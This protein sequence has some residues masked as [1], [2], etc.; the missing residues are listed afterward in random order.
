MNA[1]CLLIVFAK[2]PVPGQAKTRLAPA[3]G[4]EGAAGL[5]S[6][7]LAHTLRSAVDSGI[8]P[9]ELCCAPDTGHAQF[10]QAAG[11][12]VSLT[13]QGGG[14]LGERMERAL[15]R[16]LQHH[17]RVVLIGTDAPLLD[18]AVLRDAATALLT[19]DVVIAPAADG[20][21]VLVGLARRAPELFASVAWSTPLVMAQTRAR[22]AALGLS[23]HELPTLHDIDEPR[24]LVHVPAEWQA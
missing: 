21:Y 4:F 7:M 23:L 19:H 22:I 13:G 3:I 11:A 2:A 1:S 18:A 6:V 14:D 24:D 10:Q 9:V 20:G 8:G 5:A 15:A 12:G 17:P 16:G